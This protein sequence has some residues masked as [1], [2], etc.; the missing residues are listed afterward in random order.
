MVTF[1]HL[2]TARS[3]LVML[4]ATAAAAAVT[5]RC[6]HRHYAATALPAALLKPRSLS[7]ASA[8]RTT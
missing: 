7:F 8:Q 6:C 3:F 5:L 2:K 1:V 4:P